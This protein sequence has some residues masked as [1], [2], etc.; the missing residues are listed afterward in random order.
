MPQRRADDFYA[1]LADHERRDEARHAEIMRY[2]G[3]TEQYIKA[4][5]VDRKAV[6][7]G[8]ADLTKLIGS[9]R[10]TVA[11]ENGKSSSNRQW[12]NA[13]VIL[14]AAVLGSVAMAWLELSFHLLH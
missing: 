5:E 1:A 6:F 9:T 12:L 10:E 14:G 3:A 7:Q 13:L 2:V 8:I 11:T 4:S